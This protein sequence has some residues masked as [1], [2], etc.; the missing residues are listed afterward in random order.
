MKIFHYLDCLNVLLFLIYQYEYRIFVTLVFK[1]NK[2]VNNNTAVLL[3]L[4]LTFAKVRFDNK[5]D[6]GQ[7][8]Y[9]YGIRV[10]VL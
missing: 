5:F 9:F 8:R 6:E 1:R 2:F 4:K 7:K 10:P 3:R